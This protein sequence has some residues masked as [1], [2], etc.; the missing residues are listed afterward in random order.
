MRTLSDVFKALSDE[1]RLQ[2]LGL[3][4]EE[5]EL[6]VCDFVDVLEITQSKASR[7]LRHLVNA[8]LLDDR[9]DGTW[10][11]FRIAEKPESAQA[12]VIRLLPAVLDKRIS[13]ELFTRLADWQKSKGR[14]GSSCSDLLAERA[15][16]RA[17][18]RR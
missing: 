12:H 15:A 3:L 5:G 6:C 7:H 16:E 4:L 8:G 9:R 14:A 2:M 1:T 17:G 13:P 11:H 10:V 18:R